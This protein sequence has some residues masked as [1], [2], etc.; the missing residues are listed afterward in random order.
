MSTETI[1]Q[2]P[3]IAQLVLIELRRGVSYCSSVTNH[4]QV[5]VPR[6]VVLHYSVRC[7]LVDIGTTAASGTTVSTAHC[8]Q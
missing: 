7:S 3:P 4:Y 8:A 6:C 1:E 2:K 5:L